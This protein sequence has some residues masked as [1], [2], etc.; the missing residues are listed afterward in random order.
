LAQ[1]GYADAAGL[2]KS[3]IEGRVMEVMK[4]F[5]KVDGGK[6]GSWFGFGCCEVI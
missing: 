6:V 1:R 4:T 3:D 2:S 5:E